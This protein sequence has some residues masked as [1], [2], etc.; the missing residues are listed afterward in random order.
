ML[1]NIV[2]NQEQCYLHN[3]VLLHPVFNNLERPITF[4]FC[5]VGGFGGVQNGVSMNIFS[6]Y[7]SAS[8]RLNQNSRP[9]KFG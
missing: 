3:I 5:R 9:G 6:I 1:I 4:R 7:T 8:R 2:D